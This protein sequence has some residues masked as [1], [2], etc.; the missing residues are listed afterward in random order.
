V[1]APKGRTRVSE[2]VSDFSSRQTLQ[3]LGEL[4]GSISWFRRDPERR[5]Q[6]L[7]LASLKSPAP[8]VFGGPIEKL[9]DAGTKVLTLE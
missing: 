4:F 1:P 9:G 8:F 2:V 3:P 5:Q 6:P 7:D